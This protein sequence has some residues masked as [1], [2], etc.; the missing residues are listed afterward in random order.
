MTL[1]PQHDAHPMPQRPLAAVL[2]ACLG[3]AI[4]VTGGLVSA[5]DQASSGYRIGPKDLLEIKVFEVPELNIERRVSEE[6]TINLPL[7]GDVPVR[8]LTDTELADRLK[9]MLESRYVQ[10]ASVAV[11][12]REFRSKPISVIGAVKQPGNL[13]FSGRW[14]LLE[15]LSAAGG[16]SDEHADKIY[17]LRRADNGLSDQITV[18]VDDLM[19]RGDPDA[20]IPIFA[21]DLINV[22]A[23]VTVTVFCLG[24]VAKPGAVEFQS[25]ER[26]TLLTAIARAGGLTDRASHTIQVKR[27]DRSGHDVASEVNYKRIVAGKEPD[28]ELRGGDVVIVK[29]SFF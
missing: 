27:R 21:N 29:E 15:A 4:L 28:F 2:S 12:I 16:L 8:G 22:P 14:T 26:I 17:V 9:A 6:G 13:A 23:R 25:T 1:I 24:E 10:R 3:L 7:I 5:Q 11:Q 18:N 19:V 20:N